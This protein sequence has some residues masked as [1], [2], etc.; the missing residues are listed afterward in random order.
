MFVELSER[1][2]SYQKAVASLQ[3]LAAAEGVNKAERAFAEAVSD[4]IRRRETE[5]LRESTSC[6][7]KWLLGRRCYYHGGGNDRHA[8][9]PPATDH[10]SLWNKNGKP[11]MF[12]SQP[13]GI[14]WRQLR[15][16]VAFCEAHG[17]EVSIDARG[18]WHFPGR[19][20]RVTYRKVEPK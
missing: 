18:S 5:G 12:V 7:I 9:E 16:I 6:C 10:A 11:E 3:E 1:T 19:T 2:P 15:A 13:Y 17:L 20:L 8:C 4:E 14:S